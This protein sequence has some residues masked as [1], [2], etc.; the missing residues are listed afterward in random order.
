MI[1]L[2]KVTSVQYL[3][4][5]RLRLRFSNGSVGVR[6]F[7]DTIA[8]GSP[9]VQPLRDQAYFKRVFLEHGH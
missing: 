3:D 1:D 8:D 6:D 9:M 5:F 2:I 7:T 4:G